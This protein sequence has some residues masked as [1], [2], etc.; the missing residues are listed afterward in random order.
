MNLSEIADNLNVVTRAVKQH[1]K[2][3]KRREQ[4]AETGKLVLEA[5]GA[6]PKYTTPQGVADRVA[7]LESQTRLT[8]SLLSKGDA[9]DCGLCQRDNEIR[10]LTEMIIKLPKCW[11]LDD[12]GVLVQDVV[13]MPGMVLWSPG[14]GGLERIEVVSLE[15]PGSEWP[16]TVLKDM[17][18][19]G[20]PDKYKWAVRNCYTTREAAEAA[21]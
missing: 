6:N 5:L 7:K 11:R 18:G 14:I 13:V 19:G 2:A 9:C 10:R 8:C 17:D 16:A 12:G 20:K 1:S 21:K 15:Y 4:L 3:D